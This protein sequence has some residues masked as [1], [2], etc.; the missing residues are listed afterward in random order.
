MKIAVICDPKS[1]PQIEGKSAKK[2]IESEYDLQDNVTKTPL[3]ALQEALKDFDNK[4]SFIPL[5]LDLLI[6]IKP[7]SYDLIIKARNVTSTK[8]QS[9]QFIG[10]LD[11]TEIPYCGSQIDAITICKNKPLFKSLL[12]LNYIATPKFQI[13]KVQGGKI[14]NIRKDFKF[15]LIL[16]FF[17]AGIHAQSILD[18]VITNS[19][20]I[21]E[22]LNIYLKKSKNY[23]V[24]LEEYIIG[25]K[26]YLPILGNELN[27]NIRFLPAIET[28]FSDEE[29][30]QEKLLS[31]S[32][33][34]EKKF[35]EI[36]NPLIKHARKMAIK[37][38]NFFNCRDYAMAVF[39]LDENTNNLL[40]HELNPLTSIL[41]GG[42][43]SI[44]AE[45]LGISYSEILND[46]ILVTLL[47]YDIKLKGKYAKQLKNL[48][49]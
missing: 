43:I 20:E 6:H 45:H 49:N 22:N 34:L 40:L 44:A 10:L 29:D 46:I 36:T 47:R 30:L 16:K 27:G 17:K 7:N 38:Y 23:F 13:L 39:I 18:K 3:G 4:V 11:L 42:K 37:A 15:P 21:Y 5:N 14:P 26:F 41:P 19:D 25:R 8:H 24:L 2:T 12:Q 33:S 28:V 32:N 35:M 31:N 1:I 9:A 48:K